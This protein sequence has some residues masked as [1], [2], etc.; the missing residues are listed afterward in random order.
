MINPLFQRLLLTL[1]LTAFSL[2]VYAETRVETETLRLTFD[3]SG[4]LKSAF[5]CFP[6]CRGDNARVQQFGDES[7]I[8]IEA[9]GNEAWTLSK[10]STESHFELSFQQRSGASLDWRIPK[11]GYRLE[12]ESSGLPTVMLRSGKSFR[13]RAATGFGNWLEQSRY[14]ILNAGDV[15]QIGFDDIDTPQMNSDQWVGYRNRFWTLMAAP[16]SSVVA[17]LNPAEGKHD[18]EI[19]MNA[20]KGTWAFYLGPV[21]PIVLEQ[22]SPALGKLL[23]AGLWFLLRWICLGLFYFLAGIHT[24]IPSWG[25]A[26]MA[27]SLAVNLLMTPLTR[28]AQRFQD[29]VND[30]DIRLA[31]EL[32]RIKKNYKGEE[33]ATKILAL[34]K[35]E[36]VHPLYSLKSLI[37]VAV[38]IPVFIGAF[39]MLAENIH[40]LNSG[41]LWISDLSRPDDL[42][43]LPF[44][45]P[46]FGNELNA[47][48]FLMTGLSVMASSLHNPQAP[49]AQLRKRQVRNM[50]L[51][52]AAFFV[53]FYTFPAGMVLYWTTNNLISVVKSVWAH[54]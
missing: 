16:P 37:G 43:N 28:I 41:F 54:R 50:W 27:M 40:L 18:A 34:Y 51:L 9:Q 7:V 35:A 24:F 25:L 17:K 8:K 46:F 15:Q 5:A 52:A 44:T 6:A 36:N 29:Q 2:S 14:V 4:N 32:Q 23:Y 1:A 22:A 53:L 47:L 33:Q 38:V 42:F 31:P 48:P 26:V 45:L 30:T 49:N 21:E 3:N 39:D 19:S 12:L 13:P 20:E 11:L 10:N